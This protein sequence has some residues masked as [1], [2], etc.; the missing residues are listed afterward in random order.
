M[1][2]LTLCLT[3][4][5]NLRCSYC[6]A[7]EKHARA[8][9]E[10][11]AY[12]AIDF[13]L[14]DLRT[15][16]KL[17]DVEPKLQLCFFGG[18]PLLEWDLLQKATRYAQQ[19]CL[20]EPEPVKLILTLTTN[21]IL[22]TAERSKW[23]ISND[24]VIAG[25]LD[26]CEAM[27]NT[28]R[29]YLGGRGSHADCLPA[30]K[31][32]RFTKKASRP[33]ISVVT[34]QNLPY[35]YE[36]FLFFRENDLRSINLNFDFS[37]TWEQKDLDLLDQELGSVAIL[38]I[39]SYR[40]KKP[41]T[42]RSMEGKILAHIREQSAEGIYCKMGE[43]EIAV[44]ASG[45]FYPCSRLVGNDDDLYLRFGNVFEGYDMK[46]RLRLI[47]DRGNRS[48]QC[49]QCED[50]YRCV[51]SCG[52]VNYVASGGYLDQVSDSFCAIERM[53]MRHADTVA[54]TLWEEQNMCFIRQFYG[55]S[56]EKPPASQGE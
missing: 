52:C 31:F 13:A 29:G 12:L 1:L 28:H 56:L 30:L 41:I 38:L 11:V 17:Q 4:Q 22:L 21:L 32:F 34:P 10:E 39:E 35:L 53:L 42:V 19:R 27:H 8:M 44:A 3:H 47:Q 14:E 55:S 23:L 20:K 24:F 5:C 36:S 18:E 6:Y 45:N 2:V 37:A 16:S 43:K 49:Q 40:A 25:S 46:Q 33:I 54:E 15:Q 9:T 50:A 48:P 26:G 7:G 51:N